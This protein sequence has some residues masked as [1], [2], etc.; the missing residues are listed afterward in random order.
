MSVT[1][2]LVVGI[3]TV[4]V[5][6]I[7]RPISTFGLMQ[8]F[9]DAGWVCLAML[10]LGGVTLFILPLIERGFDVVTSM[11]LI[12]LRDPKQPL[13]RELPDRLQQVIAL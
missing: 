10:V 1:I 11:T 2:S 5:G 3:V 6:L 8:L 9:T 13:L 4:L 12:E 7:E